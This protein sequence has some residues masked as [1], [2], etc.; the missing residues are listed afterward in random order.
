MWLGFSH[1][2]KFGTPNGMTKKVQTRWFTNVDIKKDVPKLET[3]YRG[4]KRK[5]KKPDLYPKYDNYDAIEVGKV[6]QIP[7]DYDGVM[8][9]PITFF[10]KYNPDQFEIIGADE[11]VSVGSSNGLLLKNGKR[12]KPFVNGKAKYKRIFIKNKHPEDYQ[13]DLQK[14]K[15]LQAN[16][17]VFK[18]KDVFDQFVDHGEDGVFGYHG[19]FAIRPKYQREFVYDEPHQQAVIDTVIDNLPV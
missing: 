2:T 10:D 17:N 13:N 18:V 15:C 7:L 5:E 19:Q 8:G 11:S 3:V 12:D 4:R 16:T 6:L 14:G 9:V 1:P